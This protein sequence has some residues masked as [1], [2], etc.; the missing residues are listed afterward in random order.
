M[1]LVDTRIH[2]RQSLTVVAL[3]GLGAVTTHVA[4]AT[5][6]VAGLLTA[7]GTAETT[8]GTTTGTAKT[9]GTTLGALA[10]KV[11]A[12]T[13]DVAWLILLKGFLAFTA[14]EMSVKSRNGKVR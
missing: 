1:R 6:R 12:L 11:T 3:H 9:T 8:T 5:A 7:T 13:T 2:T 10:G 14:F 4:D